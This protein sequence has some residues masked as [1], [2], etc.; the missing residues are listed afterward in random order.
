MDP[1]KKESHF[2]PKI[3]LHIRGPQTCESADASAINQVAAGSKSY[4][5]GHPKWIAYTETTTT[6]T[7]YKSQTSLCRRG[8]PDNMGAGGWRHE[9]KHVLCGACSFPCNNSNNLDNVNLEF[10]RKIPNFPS[11]KFRILKIQ[12]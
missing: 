5:V 6:A 8:E 7:C 4:S 1:N 3:D 10:N 9:G 12:F 2:I 11:S